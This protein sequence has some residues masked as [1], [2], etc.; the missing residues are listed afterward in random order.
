MSDAISTASPVSSWGSTF[1]SILNT[2]VDTGAKVAVAKL[3]TKQAETVAEQKAAATIAQAN[4]DAAKAAATTANS[5]ATNWQKI[6]LIAGA[7][8]LVVGILVV[9]TRKR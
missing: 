5:S 4:A 7:A 8:V 1:Q 9:V 2:V 6:A 3:D